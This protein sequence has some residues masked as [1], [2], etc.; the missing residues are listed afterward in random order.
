VIGLPD[1]DRRMEHSGR[2]PR[3]E[4]VTWRIL[5][6]AFEVG[7]MASV[8]LCSTNYGAVPRS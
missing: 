2:V 8:R 6:Q 7:R 3:P 4:M 1:G 5:R